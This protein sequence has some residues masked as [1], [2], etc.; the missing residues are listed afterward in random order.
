MDA[1]RAQLIADYLLREQNYY[2]RIAVE[3]EHNTKPEDRI[4]QDS[5]KSGL[6]SG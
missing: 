1:Q 2:D 6:G 3:Q 5:D 4:E